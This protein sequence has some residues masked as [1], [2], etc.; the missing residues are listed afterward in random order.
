[1]GREGIKMEHRR[2]PRHGTNPDPTVT[3]VILFVSAILLGAL[4]TILIVN[5]RLAI[6]GN[7][8]F[9]R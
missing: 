1:M 3:F 5:P 4:I 7:L 9:Q 2:G 6:H 8:P